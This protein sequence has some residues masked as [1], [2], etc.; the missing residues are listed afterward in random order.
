MILMI[1]LGAHLF[2][3]FLTVT[4]TTQSIVSALGALP[5]DRWVIMAVIILIYIVLGCLMDQVAILILTVPVML[6]VIK[7]LGFD[8]V[9]F[10][11]LVIVV[12]EIGMVTPPVGLNVFVVSRFTGRPVSEVFAAVTPHILA[13]VLLIVLFCVFPQ[14]ILWLPQQ[15]HK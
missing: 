7:A 15:M 5:V 12:A 3:Y 14:L 2:G 4:Q 9:W 11:V 13:H 6:P 1:I 10:G 8:P